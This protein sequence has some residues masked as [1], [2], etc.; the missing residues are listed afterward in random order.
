MLKTTLL[1]STA[2]TLGSVASAQ[3]S[4]A[5]SLLPI[6]SAARHGGTFHVVTGT[7]TR[8]TSQPV[9]RGVND[10]VYNNTSNVDFFTS[11]GIGLQTNSFQFVDEGR[12]P[13]T[14]SAGTANRDN[15]NLNQITIGYCINNNTA[16][17]I[18]VE[19]SIYGSYIPCTD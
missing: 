5:S 9:Q 2:L 18:D 4:D 13:S 10:V 15:Y 8:T 19:I 17:A 16:S 1:L 12:I 6:Q 14:G 7:W 3:T 11:G